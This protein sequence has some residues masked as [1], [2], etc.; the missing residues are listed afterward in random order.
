MSASGDITNL[1]K[2][3]EEHVGV[4]QVTIDGQAFDTLYANLLGIRNDV[5]ALE[6]AVVPRDPR[7][8]KEPP[9]GWGPNVVPMTGGKRP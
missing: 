9:W 4:P 5:R 1:L 6:N 2:H 8:C 7:I 3:L